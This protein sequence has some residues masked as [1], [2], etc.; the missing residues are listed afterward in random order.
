VNGQTLTLTSQVIL[1]SGS[2]PFPAVIG[3]NGTSGSLPSNIFSSRNIAQIAFYHDQVTVYGN[4]KNTD[5]YYKLYPDLNIDNTGQYSAW[6]WGVSRIIDG[7]EL[8]QDVLPLDLKHLAVT[9]CSYAGKL[10]LIAGAFDERIALTIAQESGGGGYT[11]WRY[12]EQLNKTVSVET[13]SKTDYNWFKNSMKDFSSAVTKL[14]EDHHEL[15]AMVAPRALL[16]TGNPDYTWLADESGYLGSKAAKE[17]WNALGVPDRFGYSII[18]GHYHCAVP[19]SQI[20]EIEAFVEKFLLGKDTVNTEIA[21]SP[22]STNLSSWINWTTP[23]LTNGTSFFGITNLIT[24]SNSQKDLATNVEFKWNKVNDAATYI[25]QLA[26]N[27]TFSNII[28]N[29]SSSA[30]TLINVSNLT[31]GKQY[32]WRVRVKNTSGQI[33]PWS[34]TWNFSTYI[35]LPE[36]PTLISSAAYPNRPDYISLTWNKAQYATQYQV[37]L[38]VIQTFTY[39]VAS[40]TTTDTVKLFNGRSEG[41]KYYWRVQSKNINGSSSWSDIS[42]FTI[43]LPPTDLVAQKSAEGKI[44]LSWNDK[45]SVEE[46]YVIERKQSTQASFVIIDTVISGNTYTDNNVEANVNFIYRV[47]AYSENGESDYSNEASF[48]LVN[49]EHEEGIPTVYSLEQNYPNPFNPVTTIKYSIPRYSHVSLKIFDVLGNEIANMVDEMKQAGNYT[50]SFDGKNFV[51]GVYFY[52]L[53]ADN[54]LQT[55]KLLLLK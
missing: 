25:F 1:P 33:G 23:T 15:M 40:A 38:A 26:T 19:D 42:N 5:P 31:N 51:S 29:D 6:A 37:Q 28:Y 9:G 53:K 48:T 43:I 20:P 13:L 50:V 24:P 35:P 44:I 54:F 18:G 22:F 2:G 27:S 45:S 34:K 17:V 39:G 10:A 47:K 3:M 55:K 12:S 52:Q 41:V 8:V 46:G 14:P 36:K 32:Y 21:T 4:P 49:V 30:D 16:V 7:L 11:T